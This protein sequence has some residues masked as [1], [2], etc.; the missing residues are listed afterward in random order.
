[1]SKVRHYLPLVGFVIPTVV[2]GYGVVI[3]RSCIAGVNELT[4][5][6]ASTIVGAALTYV[7][8]VRSALG[9]GASNATPWRRRVERLINRQAAA[10]RGLFGRFLGLLWGLEHREANRATLELLAIEPG[11]RVLE[12]GCGPGAA[13]EGAAARVG[14]GEVVGVDVSDV[15]VAAARRRNREAV[16][17]GRVSVR[18]IDGTNVGAEPA[19][20][21]RIFSVHCLYFWKDPEHM[22]S[23]LFEALR[24]GG[25][26]VLAFRP[27]GPDV[28]ARFREDETYQFYEPAELE[29][30]LTRAGF[31][32]VRTVCAPGGV[33]PLRWAVA[34]RGGEAVERGPTALRHAP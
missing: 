3:P 33:G 21:D 14:S 9:A 11:H 13:L 8:G 19:S 22:L 10:P 26:L 24:P 27:A 18:H 7:A 12:V 25:R 4:L 23:Q 1:M 2:I 6:F 32:A 16:A 30:L 31:V 17:R 5:G 34:E 15:M 29:G 28:P 20:F